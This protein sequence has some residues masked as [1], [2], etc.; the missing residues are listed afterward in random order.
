MCFFSF[1][2]AHKVGLFVMATGRYVEFVDPLIDSAEKHFCKD[3]E[4]TYFVF[5]DQPLKERKNLVKIY[6][7]RLG[8]PLDTM[9]RYHVY[10]ENRKAWEDMDYVYALD[11]DMLFV[12]DVG[13]EIIGERVATLHPG[14]IGK[15]GPHSQTTI[16]SNAFIH[17]KNRKRYFAGGFYGGSIKEVL[18]LFEINIERIDDDLSR[19][20]I[21]AWHDESFWN[22]YLTEHPPTVVLSPSYC[23]PES[24][25]LSYEKKLLALDK[26]HEDLR[27]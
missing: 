7:K 25:S 1:L 23:Y 5:T 6:Q 15:L 21:P 3:H 8:W 22:K 4:V 11:A 12:G 27:K 16:F 18:K 14:F 10:Y 20:V 19:G 2:E 24:W 9:N 17:K 13:T 26:E